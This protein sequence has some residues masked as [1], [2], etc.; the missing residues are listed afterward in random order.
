MNEIIIEKNPATLAEIKQF[1][2]ST[3]DDV[4]KAVQEA[5]EGF[6]T[7]SSLSYSE[8]GAYLLKAREYILDHLDEIA[9]VISES[10]G[11]PKV[12][13]LSSDIFPICD[14]IYYFAKNTESLLKPEK[15]S[16][17]VMALL[18]RRSK[19][20]YEPLGVV[21]IIS[22]WNFPFSI[23]MSGIVMALMAGNCV[24]L[25]PADAT[26]NVGFK[27]EEIFRSIHLPKGVFT[28]L[29]GGAETG[30]ALLNSE[31]NKVV[32][33][34]SVRIGKRVMEVCAKR[35]I[36]CTLELGGKDPMIVCHDAHL[37]N[38]A[39]AAA[40][41][42][43]CNAGQVCASVERLYVDEKIADV[44]IKKVV[45]KTKKLKQGISDNY[46]IDIGPLTTEAQL[47]IVE[48]QIEEAKNRGAKILTGGERNL[49]Y[50]GYFFKP[51]VLTQVDH[52]FRCMSEETFGP[53]LPIMTFKTE[54]EAVRLANDSTYG[55]TAS[56]WTKDLKRGEKLAKQ[57]KSGTVMVNEC[58]YSYAISQ[59]PWGG[60]NQSG[61]GRTHGKVGLHELVHMKHI[62]VNLLPFIQDFWWFGYNQKLYKTL[63]YL[64][65][66]L[67]G[68]FW[69]KTKGILRT[70]LETLRK[71]Y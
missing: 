19:I 15:L 4:S 67:T 31:L 66:N 17:G 63:K 2:P 41:G 33:T 48:T 8:R 1:K 62:H 25:K 13:A 20:Y 47:K 24:V 71:K 9:A 36:P 29:P 35:L 26:A 30:E 14:L 23:P 68:N 38:A 12:E 51:T 58:T 44:F 46:D 5:H 39:K 53:T 50:P 7:W 11:K 27:I 22:P 43:F 34:G 28:H 61:F 69:Q 56:V 16:I 37:E 64:S 40:W 49:Q 57:I 55:L 59:T 70:L 60:L 32:F 18:G 45:E 52:T 3:P 65:R 10:N 6:E 42:A 54:E 21:G